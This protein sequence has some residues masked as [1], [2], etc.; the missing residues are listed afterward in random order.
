MEGPNFTLE[1][2]VYSNTFS[3][4]IKLPSILGLI[5]LYAHYYLTY[6]QFMFWELFFYFFP[7]VFSIYNPVS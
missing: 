4:M 6:D 1:N 7:I 2:M 5:L 3:R